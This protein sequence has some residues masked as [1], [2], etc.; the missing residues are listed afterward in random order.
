MVRRRGG[1]GH[2]D[3]HHCLALLVHERVFEHESELGGAVG[4]MAA[5]G[6]QC[7]D[8][9]LQSKQ[10]LVDLGTCKIDIG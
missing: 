3:D 1:R 6:V 10:A 9:F 5:P 4:Y 7:A 2:V 8:A